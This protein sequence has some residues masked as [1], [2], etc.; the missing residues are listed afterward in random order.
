VEYCS[1]LALLFLHIL[2]GII[3]I[4]YLPDLSK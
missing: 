2:V 4:I 1:I 3:Y